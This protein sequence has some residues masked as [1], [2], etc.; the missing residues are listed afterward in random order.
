MT[1]Y[2]LAG[3]CFWCLDALYRQI[4]GVTVVESG[5]AG[6]E[7][8]AAYE[9]VSAGKTSYAEAVRIIFDES[10]I[11]A[12][13]ILDI[14]FAAHNPTTL[15]QQGADVGPQYRSAMFYSDSEQKTV[16]EAAREHAKEIWDRPI[17]TQIVPLKNYRPAEQHH[18]DYFRKN[19]EAGY[20]NVVITPKL[21]KIRAS[22]SQWFKEET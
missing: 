1:T 13:V 12:S 14:F 5:Y 21:S 6:G 3:G 7:G 4:K 15:N 2:V 22:H 10:I 16:F 9:L 8:D 18:Q 11:P 20:C 19:P 17:V